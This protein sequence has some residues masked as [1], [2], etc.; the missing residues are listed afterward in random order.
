MMKRN[1]IIILIIV[2]ILLFGIYYVY[3]SSILMVADPS[4]SCDLDI[5]L[6]CDDSD[7]ELLRSRLGECEGGGNFQEK[8]DADH[9]GCITLEDQKILF[10][11][12]KIGLPPQ[13]R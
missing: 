2:V 13:K 9:D 11:T 4:P 1:L 12:Y 8:A 3:K 10:P 6:D 5:D 7:F